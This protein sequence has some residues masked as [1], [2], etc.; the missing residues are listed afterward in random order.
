MIPNDTVPSFEEISQ[1]LDNIQTLL[2]REEK[3]SNGSETD[4]P[5]TVKTANL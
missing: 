1:A 5:I 2:N 3:Q 4:H